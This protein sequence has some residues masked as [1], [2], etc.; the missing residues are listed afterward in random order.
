VVVEPLPRFVAPMLLTATHEVPSASGWALE[1]KW[2]GMRAQLR[3]DDRRVTVRSRPGRDCSAQFP[4]L[5]AIAGALREQAVFD[6]ELVCF[7]AE[8][9]PDFERVRSRLRARTLGAVAL[10]R[11]KAPATLV[12]FDVLHM[13]GEA[14]RR[15]PYRNR[16]ALLDELALNGAAWRTPRAFAIDEDLARVTRERFLEGIVA[17]RLDAPYQPGRRGEAWLKHKHRHRERLIVTAWRP[18]ERRRPDE[19]LVARRDGAGTLRHAGGVRFGLTVHDRACLRA[20]LERIEEPRPRRSRIRRVRPL[21]EVDVDY[22]GRPGGPLR[23]PVLRNVALP[24]TAA[25]ATA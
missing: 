2:D 19:V 20:L 24:A 17:K 5:Q 22:H 6:G 3:F 13:G 18:G 4:E 16:R 21:I 1:V 12:L 11:A 7:D 25:A 9:L 23:D 8:G 14:T 10:A 15:Q